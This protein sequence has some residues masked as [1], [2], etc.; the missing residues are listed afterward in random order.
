[1][2]F[3]IGDK[4]FVSTGR[5]PVEIEADFATARRAFTIKAAHTLNGAIGEVGHDVYEVEGMLCVYPEANLRL[6]P[7][8]FRV[9]R[10]VEALTEEGAFHAAR[11]PHSAGLSYDGPFAGMT[12][13]EVQ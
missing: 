11:Y 10:E 2:T 13:E 8:R 3:N 5:N 6:T 12:V 4:V 1:M 9:Y 7:R